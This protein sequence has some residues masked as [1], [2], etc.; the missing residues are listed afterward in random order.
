VGEKGMLRYISFILILVFASGNLLAAEADRANQSEALYSF[1]MT[2]AK[3]EAGIPQL[4]TASLGYGCLGAYQGCI[5]G[6]SASFFTMFFA[7]AEDLRNEN[8]M[9]GIVVGGTVLGTALG[10]VLGPKA[11][12]TWEKGCLIGGA[13][14]ATGIA[15]YTLHWIGKHIV[16]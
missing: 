6:F 11:D 9:T 2:D 13:V 15:L 4:A 12:K 7:F 16:Y 8:L 3:L 1:K 10:G 5:L 14:I